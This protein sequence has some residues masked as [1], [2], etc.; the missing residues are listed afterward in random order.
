[1]TFYSRRLWRLLSPTIA[2]LCTPLAGH[3]QQVTSP[4]TPPLQT[5]PQAIS[6]QRTRQP[7]VSVLA[8]APNTPA[9]PQNNSQNN[10]RRGRRRRL[11]PKLPVEFVP[12]G[13]IS[14][15]PVF[16]AHGLVYFASWNSRVYALDSATGA[17]KW[18][19]IAPKML[20][21]SPAV[22][23]DG[24][25]VYAGAYDGKVY[26]LDGATGALRW[27]FATRSLLNTAPAV[28]AQGD[29]VYVGGY[30]RTVYALAAPTGAVKWRAL[31]GAAASSPALGKDGAVYVGADQIYALKPADGTPIW[32]APTG[33][34][35]ASPV[36]AGPNGAVY[37][38]A[39]DEAGRSQICAL[40]TRTGHQTWAYPL[41]E[42]M[43]SAP[44]A[45]DGRVYVG[46]DQVY[47]LRQSNGHLVW[48]YGQGSAPWS[49]PTVGSGIVCAG[50]A[51]GTLAALDAAT[52]DLLWTF[53]TNDALLSFPRFGPHGVVYVACEGNS[54]IYAL[55]GRTGKM[56]WQFT[57]EPVPTTPITPLPIIP[58]PTRR[59]TP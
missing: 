40:D 28:S 15:A 41:G 11:P 54:K 27:Q 47:V 56:L 6:R 39:H 2:L 9:Q 31:V 26:A 7:R 35:A 58:P 1:M 42:R 18:K 37:A 34:D 33:Y 30:D 25:A 4:S 8:P 23:P 50:N 16:G 52:G 3:A 22:G 59:T 32:K 48:Q 49:T 53:A 5:A 43:A 10:R 36:A 46:A 13:T 14:S 38:Q 20:N 57:Q 55:E 44:L 21:A 24:G 45:L 19:F 51:D 17:L 29:T 12:G